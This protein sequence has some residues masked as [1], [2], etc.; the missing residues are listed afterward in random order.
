MVVR[1]FVPTSNLAFRHELGLFFGM[2]INSSLNFYDSL[3]LPPGNRQGL[4]SL[5]STL[6]D[7]F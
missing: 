5:S 7:I 6:L 1:E 4:I 2:T 3:Q